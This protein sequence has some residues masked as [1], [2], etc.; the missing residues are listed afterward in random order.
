[1]QVV[2]F[3]GWASNKPACY[4]STTKAKRVATSEAAKEMVWLKRLID[5][6]TNKQ[7]TPIIYIDN[8]AAI[9]LMKNP[10]FY[11]RLREAVREGIIS[12]LPIITNEQL[13]DMLTKPLLKGR[14]NRLG[15][16]TEKH[17]FNEG[18]LK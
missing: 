4:L 15:L 17:I 14:I 13:A 12:V 10:E 8:E 5:E 18:V 6:L 11:R 9:K 2:V 7:E 3:H 16:I 1:M